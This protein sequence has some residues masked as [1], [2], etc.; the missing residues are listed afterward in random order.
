[1]YS[2]KSP[3]T[4]YANYFLAMVRFV[5]IFFISILL[6]NPLIEKIV[7][8][9][10]KPKAI[11][12]MDNS[13]SVGKALGANQNSLVER[14]KGAENAL[15][16]NNFEVV[17]RDLDGSLSDWTELNFD[18]KFTN[19]NSALGEIQ[20]EY[21]N[22]N[23]TKVFLVSDGIYNQGISPAHRPFDFQVYSVGVGD[24]IQKDDLVLKNVLFNKISYAGRKAPIV[25]EVVNFGYNDKSSV[26]EIWKNGKLE[27]SKE[28]QFQTGNKL[29][30][31]ELDVLFEEIGVQSLSIRI[32]GLAEENTL[33]NNS[34]RIFVDVVDGKQKIL[35]VAPSPHPD[36]KAISAIVQKNEGFEL[37]R[38]VI[39]IDNYKD[40]S[41]DLAIIHQA[42]DRRGVT[43]RLV[44]Q[45]KEKNVPLLLI[46]GSEANMRLANKE[47]SSL[48]FTQN[49]SQKDIISASINR[50][51]ESFNISGI[52]TEVVESFPPLVV[53]YGE[54]NLSLE[55]KVL[56]HQQ[57]GSIVTG[58]PLL[59][60]VE[61]EDEKL[62]FMMATDFWKWRLQEYAIYEKTDVFDGLF[63]KSIQYLSTKIDKR[64][65]RF[66]PVKNEF[67]SNETIEFQSELYNEIFER[68]YNR[69][70]SVKVWKEGELYKE[71]LFTPV[72]SFSRLELTDFEEGSYRYEAQVELNGK[73]E[74]AR[75]S[76]VVKELQLEVINEV[77]DFEMLRQLSKKSGAYF[78]DASDLSKFLEDS[79]S[80]SDP[81]LLHSSESTLP[82]INIRWLLMLTICFMAIEWFAR[83]HQGGY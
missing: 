62:G 14:L 47:E 38:N 60:F 82:M 68:I 42:Y 4:R 21:E 80:F 81:S 63:L 25:A 77:A 1:M 58:K 20:T 34:K 35:L 32:K 83:K 57:V 74:I 33:E 49:R 71:A 48:S 8:T 44:K 17:R 36:L 16:Q 54:F 52:D 50:D 64:K 41:Y 72:S 79:Q 78:Y 76:F 24:T 15:I 12:L 11:F 23:L 67:L 37:V 69:P 53:P 2:R 27:T 70:V 65:F 22:S 6:L 13:I 30:R 31:I 43:S 7:T 5:L 56:F 39:G 75:G 66:E 55:A 59:F 9:V 26:I 3:W 45:L 29:Q 73:K 18:S 19:L 51:F 28:V 46:L 40:D 10:E 61:R